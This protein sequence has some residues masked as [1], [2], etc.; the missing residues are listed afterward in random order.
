[1]GHLLMVTSNKPATPRHVA[2]VL[3]PDY[4][5]IA[6]ASAIE[7]LR[8]ANQIGEQ[9]VYQWSCHTLNG[10]PVRASNGLTTRPDGDLDAI[11]GADLV[12]V[13]AGLNVERQRH[14]TALLSRLRYLASHGATIGAI[15]TGSY[16]LAKAGLLDNH[17]CTIHWE[18][19]RSFQEEF[20]H[21]EAT[22][23]LF[24]FDSRRVTSAGGT[25]SLDMML[26]YVSTQFGV[27]L[28]TS[29]ADMMM[30]HHIR[31]GDDPQRPD[32]RV[33]LG[34]SHP[35]LVATIALM[36]AGIEA[37]LSCRSLAQA[38]GLSS[39]QL[40][41]LFAQHLGTTPMRYYLRLRLF[42]SRRLLKQTSMSV[43]RIGLSCG[44]ISASHFS[45]CYRETFNKTPSQDRAKP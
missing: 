14:S 24:E 34:V 33:R 30:H 8:L 36:E 12:V 16:L 27:D 44:F 17:R 6:F 35:K 4:S 20:P 22:S 40:E 18:N 28:A 7:P 42:Q 10:E 2:F 26:H 11:T 32:L 19:L 15:C 43:L 21:I 3:V 1:M 39:R 38:V 5:L 9:L 37:P 23:E 29:I 25:A 41:R 13:C 45:K 31:P